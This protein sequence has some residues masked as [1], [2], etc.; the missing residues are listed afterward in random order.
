MNQNVRRRLLLIKVTEIVEVTETIT[1]LIEN[2][3]LPVGSGAVVNETK[4]NAMLIELN[5]SLPG[6]F[7]NM[8]AEEVNLFK[9]K[10]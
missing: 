4:S 7:T 8:D 3:V 6:I 2:H 10:K 9:E 5:K 1:I